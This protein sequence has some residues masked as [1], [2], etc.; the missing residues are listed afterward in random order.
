MR[1]RVEG[2]KKVDRRKSLQPAYVWVNNATIRI[3]FCKNKQT[4]PNQLVDKAL[5]VVN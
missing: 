5:N 1:R 2:R 4:K 3:F